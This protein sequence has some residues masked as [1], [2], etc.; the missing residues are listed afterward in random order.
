MAETNPMEFA[1]LLS[2]KL[3][4]V[5]EDQKHTETFRSKLNA[6]SE[7]RHVQTKFWRF[8]VVVAL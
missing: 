8:F 6:M 5:Q 7:V 3:L 1:K 4:R 2:D